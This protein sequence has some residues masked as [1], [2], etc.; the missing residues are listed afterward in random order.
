MRLF[1]RYD[2]KEF[3]GEANYFALRHFRLRQFHFV[4]DQPDVP[5]CQGK[6]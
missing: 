4:A 5:V 1:C 2:A 6:F 3:E